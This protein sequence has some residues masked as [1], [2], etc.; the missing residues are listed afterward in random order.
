MR[1]IFGLLTLILICLCCNPN[2]STA[3]NYWGLRNLNTCL[4]D[5]AYEAFGAYYYATSVSW[6]RTEGEDDQFNWAALDNS[7]NFIQRYDGEAI[8][9]VSCSSPWATDEEIRAPNDLDRDTPL[10]DD[11]PEN[12]YSESI[13]DFAYNLVDHIAEVDAAPV[14]YLRFVNE[15]WNNWVMD[16]RNHTQ[17]VDDYIRCLRTFYLASHTS[18]NNNDIEVAVSHG[19]FRLSP[20]LERFY[21]EMGEE[22]ATLQDSLILLLQSR[23]ERH[24]TR[25]NSWDDLRNRVNPRGGMPPAYWADAMAGQTDWLDWF[26]IHYHF[27]PRFIFDEIAAFEQTV[28]DSGGTN[29]PWLAAEAAMQ[30]AQG[31]LT[32]YEEGF[33]AGDMVRKWILGMAVGLEGICTPLTGF[34]PE[35]FFGL[36]DD[37]PEEYLS[38]E[39]YRFLRTLVQPENN[40]LNLSENGINIYRFEED[41]GLLDVVWHDALFDTDDDSFVYIPLEVAGQRVGHVFDCIGEELEGFIPGET[42]SF[43]VSQEPLIFVWEA[44]EDKRNEDQTIG[45]P[46]CL[47]LNSLYPNPFNSSL[48]IRYSVSMKSTIS[49]NIFSITG[50]EVYR[51]NK[52]ALPGTNEAAVSAINLPSG[53]YFISVSNSKTTH[54]KKALLLK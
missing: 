19:G 28:E 4:S 31:G 18:A 47:T 15:P 9:V 49:I 11:P 46:D 22:D 45:L 51:L 29:R 33:H 40:P 42:D 12:G 36:F 48:R 16:G 35:R 50:R 37:Q 30:L 43:F 25:I 1:T 7:L 34:P 41:S 2:I 10:Q 53:I 24:A 54:V 23:F 3:R 8:L 6:A 14:P 38:A 39:S 20:S 26:D 13:Y 21:F 5:E 52:S 27:K 32:E 17:D 44:W